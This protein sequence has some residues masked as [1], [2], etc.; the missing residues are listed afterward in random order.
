[1]TAAP[2]GAA[3]LFAEANVSLPANPAEAR[4]MT[5]NQRCESGPALAGQFAR[6]RFVPRAGYSPAQ[7][8]RPPGAGWGRQ[9]SDGATVTPSSPRR[10]IGRERHHFVSGARSP[11]LKAESADAI[12]A[13]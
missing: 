10:A 6:S 8:P 7:S 11:F 12:V 13:A 9:S 3:E 4:D 1:M 5:A 2:I